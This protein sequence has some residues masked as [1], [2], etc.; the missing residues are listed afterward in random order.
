M[1]RTGE[2]E[3]KAREVS[4]APASDGAG[5]GYEREALGDLEPVAVEAMPEKAQRGGGVIAGSGSAR[6]ARG[7][8]GGVAR[9]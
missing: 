8:D 9:R 2:K 7:T 3:A 1:N 5:D 4:P 6:N